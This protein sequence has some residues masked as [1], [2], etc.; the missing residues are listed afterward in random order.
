[1]IPFSKCPNCGGDVIEK[2][3]E[4][5]IKGGND[6]ATVKV[7]AEVCLHCGERLFTKETI[8]FFERI[9]I[10]LEQNDTTDFSEVGTAYTVKS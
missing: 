1:M 6:T 4:E 9:K 10:K 7:K 2:E 5:I 3:V 8:Q